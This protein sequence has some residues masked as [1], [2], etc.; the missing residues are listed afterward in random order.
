M[1]QPNAEFLR[2]HLH[3]FGLVVS[4]QVDKELLVLSAAC[5]KGDAECGA[6]MSASQPTFHQ[7]QQGQL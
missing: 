4:S 7:P 2:L 6:C 1:R 3:C 5:A